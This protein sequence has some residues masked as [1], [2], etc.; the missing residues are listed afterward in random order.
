MKYNL[1]GTTDIKVSEICLGTMTWGSQN[2]EQEGFEQM[3]YA[4]S[5]GVNFFDTAELYP[6]PPKMETKHRTEEIIGNWFTHSKKRSEI[7][8][9][10]KV[11]GI[12]MP[13]IRGGAALSPSEINIALEDSLKRLQTDYI[14]LY[15]LHWPNRPVYHF[16]NHKASVIDLD[17]NKVIDEHLSIL[18]CLDTHVKAGK[19]RHIGVSDD[20]AWGVMT[21]LNLSQHHNLPRMMSVQNEY[22]LLC[23]WYD[24]ELSEIS[25][26]E[27]CGLLAWSPLATGNLSGKYLDGK[28]PTGSRRDYA[29]SRTFRDTPQTDKA[30]RSYIALAQEYNIDVCQMAIAFTLSRPFMTASIIGA[31]TMAQLKNNIASK[32]LTLSQE[33]LDKID[34]IYHDN[35]FCY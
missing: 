26:L 27:K 17:K 34:A 9:A 22:S 4:L 35:A 15:Q 28:I 21:Y 13:H 16:G 30:V 23:R 3:D 24:K 20:T 5:A 19:I 14:D 7:V 6:V 29:G 25:V 1:L 32:D 2:T 18:E 12:G 33:I 31:T 10:T 8:L 11:K